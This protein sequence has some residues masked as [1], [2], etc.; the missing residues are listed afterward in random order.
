MSRFFTDA[1]ESRMC[2]GH[3]CKRFSR[4][5][6]MISISSEQEVKVYQ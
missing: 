5:D 1:R 6:S 4:V 3:V 2:T